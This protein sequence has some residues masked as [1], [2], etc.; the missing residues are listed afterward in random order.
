MLLWNDEQQTCYILEDGS[1]PKLKKVKD[2]IKYEIRIEI[3]EMMRNNKYLNI[4]TSKIIFDF[5]DEMKLKEYKPWN[6]Y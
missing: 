2:P 6:F 3:W 4:D 1:Y 5:V